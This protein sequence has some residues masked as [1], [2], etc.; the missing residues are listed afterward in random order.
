MTITKTKRNRTVR[1]KCQTTSSTATFMGLQHWL[2]HMYERL[3]WMVLAHSRGYDD[4]VS[5]YK[6]SVGRLEK[7]IQIK[8]NEVNSPD[9]R[10]D[11]QIMMEEVMVLKKHVKKDFH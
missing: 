1:K 11:L 4:K 9:H 2:V 10:K 7:E 8:M 3:G 6:K 5:S